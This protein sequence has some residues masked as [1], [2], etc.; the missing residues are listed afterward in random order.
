M[1]I[2]DEY[3]FLK[4]SRIKYVKGFLCKSNRTVQIGVDENNDFTKIGY[5]DVSRRHLSHTPFCGCRGLIK[6]AKAKKRYHN[7]MEIYNSK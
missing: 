7:N 2:N 5:T 6:N 3:N 4:K 1:D